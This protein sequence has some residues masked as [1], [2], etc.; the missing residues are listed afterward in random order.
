MATP[1]RLLIVEDSSDDVKLLVRELQRGGYQPVYEQ[2]E[3][4]PA[5]QA[6]LERQTWDAVVSDHSAPQFNSFAV[7]E[8]LKASRLDMPFIIVSGTIGEERAVQAMKAGAHDYVLKGNL[9]RLVPALTRALADAEERRARRAAERALRE[10]QQQ[11]VLELATA[12]EATLEGWARALDLRDRETEGHSRRVADLTLRLARRLGVSEAEHVH[13]RRGALLHDIGKVGVP[14]AVLL[15]AS[16]L[17]PEEWEIMR[18]HPAYALELLAPIAYL[19]PALDIPH[20]HHEKWDG[21]GYPR[22]L[23]GEEIPLAARIF[24]A[25]DIWD[26]V[27]SDRPYRS[28]WS[29]ER[30]R[31]HIASLAGTHLD[32]TITQTF[33]DMVASFDR[34]SGVGEGNADIEVGHM[35]GTILVVDDDDATRSLLQRW[36]AG[37]GYV[38]VMADSGESAL[39]AVARHHPNLVLLDIVMPQPDGLVVCRQLKDDPATRQIPIIFMTGR[40]DLEDE[41]GL[42]DI[43]ADDY[44]RKPVD[45]HELRTRIRRV[46]Q[47][48]RRTAPDKRL[49]QP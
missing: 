8:L 49:G 25:A 5:M 47:R 32:P 43:E 37:D 19:S 31:A 42:C 4:A 2:V 45:G 7:L 39:A 24:A 36:L 46:L 41:R 13:L 35:S 17:T 12:Y 28:A 20:C 44:L 40:Q 9:K 14:D 38:V 1:L 27:R 16:A 30:A 21:T 48:V 6:A 34:A 23:K 15:K 3:S 26:A 22:G 29:A 18:R 10:G 33:L 11:T